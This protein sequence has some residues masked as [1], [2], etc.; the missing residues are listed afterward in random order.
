L[1]TGQGTDGVCGHLTGGEFNYQGAWH[2]VRA[3]GADGS[4]DDRSGVQAAIDAAEL[5]GG[6]EFTSRLTPIR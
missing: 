1:P 4:G 2:D 3:Y 6:E 5:A